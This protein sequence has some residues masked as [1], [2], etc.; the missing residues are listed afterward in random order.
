MVYQNYFRYNKAYFI[1]SS[2]DYLRIHYFIP[3]EYLMLF[4]EVRVIAS[5]IRSPG[6]FSVFKP[7][8]TVSILLHISTFTPIYF[9]GLWG[10][11]RVYQLQQASP[12]SSCSTAFSA[13]RQD[14]CF[15]LS[16]RF[17][18]FL[19]CGPCD[20]KSFQFSRILLNVLVNLSSVV[21]WSLYSCTDF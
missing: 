7:I 18:F 15:C 12:S 3:C 20:S 4:I 6:L 10:P 5:L 16:F 1:S 2:K 19:L 17:P 11:F 14:P 13:F 8:L 21:V 9:P